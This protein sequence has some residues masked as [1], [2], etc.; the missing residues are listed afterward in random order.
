VQRHRSD[1]LHR[2]E[3]DQDAASGAAQ[4]RQG[5]LRAVHVA[6]D[7]DSQDAVEL[8]GRDVLAPAPHAD[9]G[10][11]DPRVDPA[12]PLHGARPMPLEAPRTTTDC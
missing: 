9:G 2:G 8:L 5:G 11:V 1:A 4:R 12:V 3:A 6:E 10:G 7:A